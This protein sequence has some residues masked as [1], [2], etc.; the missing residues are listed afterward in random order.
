MI[1]KNNYIIIGDDAKAEE[2]KQHLIEKYGI[3]K[4]EIKTVFADEISIKVLLDET[5]FLPLFSNKKLIHI[6]N[7]E[8]INKEDCKLLKDLFE[9]PK[10]DI[11][12]ILSGKE[13]KDVL[14]DY[15]DIML[16]EEVPLELFPAIFYMKGPKDKKKIISL[17]REYITH[18][19]HDFPAVINASF[20]YLRN[21]IKNKKN[22][23]EKIFDSYQKLY[24][25]DF[26]LKIG[27]M[28]EEEFDVFL[29]SILP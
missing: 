28:G 27:K 3:E 13:I 20:I 2:L 21:T 9:N 29:F 1:D 18:N 25:L 15:V 6:K 10:E 8:K 12:L 5:G 14:A 7:C 17:I 23:D 26:N 16:K 24:N 22:I 4:G 19:P 11:F